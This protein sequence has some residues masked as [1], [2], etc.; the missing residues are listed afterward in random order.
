MMSPIRNK[1]IIF[2]KQ[3]ALHPNI[4]RQS[5]GYSPGNQNRR[6]RTALPFGGLPFRNG[7]SDVSESSPLLLI[8]AAPLCSAYF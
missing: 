5:P 7:S 3:T 2:Q 4:R 8:K 6:I 1:S